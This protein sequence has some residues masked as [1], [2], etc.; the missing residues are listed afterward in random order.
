[1]RAMQPRLAAAAALLAAG[2]IG[3]P[4]QAQDNGQGATNAITP[5]STQQQPGVLQPK[6][7]I[8]GRSGASTEQ[9]HQNDT[10]SPGGR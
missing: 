3:S 9:A 8:H 4:A 7:D 10:A 6:P 1:M 5:P 2:L